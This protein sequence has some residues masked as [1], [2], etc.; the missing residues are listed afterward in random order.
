MTTN[1]LIDT[2]RQLDPS[3]NRDVVVE[4]D[5]YT[6]PQYAVSWVHVDP[7]DP[8]GDVVIEVSTPDEEG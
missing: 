7:N 2:L 8:N 5:G 3:G 4:T 6:I 1:Q